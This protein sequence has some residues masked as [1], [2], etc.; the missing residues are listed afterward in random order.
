MRIPAPPISAVETIIGEDLIAEKED[1][2]NNVFLL[3]TV[4]HRGAGLDAPEN[5]LEAF[6]MVNFV[7]YVM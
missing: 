6:N 5:S 3:K 4:A 7:G 2:D 1:T